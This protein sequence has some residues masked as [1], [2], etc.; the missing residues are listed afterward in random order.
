QNAGTLETSTW[1]ISLNGALLRTRDMALSFGVNIDR[2]RQTVTKL[3]VAPY[4]WVPNDTQGLN[5]FRVEEGLP[6]GTLFGDKTVRTLEDLLPRGIS[7]DQLSQFQIND[8]GIVVWVGGD[9]SDPDLWMKGISDQL[10]GTKATLNLTPDE[11]GNTREEEFLWGTPIQF[12]NEEGTTDF[13]IGDTTPDFNWSFFT[14]FEWKGFSFYG[15]LDSQVGGDIY[16]HTVQ[17]GLGV[18]QAQEAADQTD[19]PDELKKPTLYYD[20]LADQRD[21]VVFDGS[22]VKVRELSV[23]YSFNRNQLGG[24][25]GGLL[26]KV[27]IGIVGRNL[28]TFDNY[29]QGYDPEVGISTR[30]AATDGSETGTSAVIGKIDS[31]SYPNFRTFTGVLELEF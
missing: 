25:F 9:G 15:L 4:N 13:K 2:T 23:K 16:S 11:N 20:E 22:Y 8:E 30:T 3:D 27:S 14:N 28:F 7:Q 19:K 6:L 31:F 5:V 12:E 1:E 24:L 21:V 10:W 18:E 29:N 26:N 17:W